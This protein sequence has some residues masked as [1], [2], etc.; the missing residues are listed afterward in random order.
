MIATCGDVAGDF[1]GAV[2]AEH[3]RF[4]MEGGRVYKRDEGG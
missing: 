2:S 3:I 1:E 4:V